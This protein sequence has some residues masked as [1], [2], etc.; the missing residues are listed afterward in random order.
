MRMR[1]FVGALATG[2]TPIRIILVSTT[3]VYGD[4]GGDWVDEDTPPRPAT[5]RAH[6]RL[7]AER[8]LRAFGR[9]QDVPVVV[10]RVAG[11]YA[12]DRLPITRLRAR[13]P[14]IS[15]VD[16]PYTNRIHAE[17]L[18]SICM[19]AAERGGS[20]RVYNVSDGNPMKMT[21]YFNAIAD[22]LDLPA[23]PIVDRRDAERLL[24]PGML[25]YLN[26]SRRLVNRRMLVDLG[27]KLR[28]PNLKAGL[29]H[30]LPEV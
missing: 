30:G 27:I 3:A 21:A 8:T 23:P 2:G 18:V 11:I 1:A 4:Q 7:D 29:A 26:E 25:S 28:Y 20:D 6:R 15:E 24:S 17:D 19:A 13:E 10:L 14:M 22:A 5:Q 9:A 16:S 12:A